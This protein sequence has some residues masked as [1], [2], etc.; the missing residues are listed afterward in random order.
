MRRIAVVGCIG[1]GKSTFARRLGLILGITVTHLDRLWW[2]DGDYRITG[3][4]TVAERTMDAAEFRAVQMQLAAEDKWIIDGN[5][6]CDLDTRLS[7]ADTVVFL[8]LNRWICMWRLARRHDRRRPDYPPAAREGVGWLWLLLRSIW[9]YRSTRRP[10][11]EAA[12]HDHA[13]S[14]TVFHLTRRASVR[15]FISGLEANL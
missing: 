15:R 10:L 5:Y 13:T 14:A 11:I 4:A 1:A 9:T 2:Q 12:I 8:D 7:R 3:P 6:I